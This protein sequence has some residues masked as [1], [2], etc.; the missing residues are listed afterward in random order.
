[1]RRRTHTTTLESIGANIRRARVRRAMTQEALAEALDVDVRHL[2]RLERGSSGLS[3]ALF[4]ELAAEL[5]VRPQ[6]L[7]RAAKPPEAKPGRPRSP[8]RRKP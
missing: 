5:G 4:L 1:M 6:A 7:L 2:Q 8:R 3:L